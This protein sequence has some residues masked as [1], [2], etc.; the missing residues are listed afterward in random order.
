MWYGVV[1]TGVQAAVAINMLSDLFSHEYP[2]AVEVLLKDIYADNVNPRTKTEP[3][4]EEQI[5][6]TLTV[7]GKG[8]FGSKY[9][10]TVAKHPEKKLVLTESMLKYWVELGESVLNPRLA[11]LNLNKKVLGTMKPN[12][13]VLIMI[14]D[15]EP[16]MTRVILTRRIVVSILAEL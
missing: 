3:K 14:Q 13:E 2:C 16:L 7:L 6:A 15:A 9:V 4:R 10:V 5:Q 1:P 11:E 12:I 8:G